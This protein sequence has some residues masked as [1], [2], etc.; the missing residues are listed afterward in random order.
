MTLDQALALCAK[1]RKFGTI[2]LT[3]EERAVKNEARKIK[4]QHMI[5]TDKQYQRMFNRLCIGTGRVDLLNKQ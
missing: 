3:A 1:E 5:A 2:S 4:H